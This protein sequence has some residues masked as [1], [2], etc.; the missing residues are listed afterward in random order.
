[1]LY[2]TDYNANQDLQQKSNG[3]VIW[4][5]RVLFAAAFLVCGLVV[6]PIAAIGTAIIWAQKKV[7]Q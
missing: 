6:L 4:C 1:M 2:M 5:L 7:T 3:L